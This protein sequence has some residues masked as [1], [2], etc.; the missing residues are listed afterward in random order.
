M[1]LLKV[2]RRGDCYN[3]LKK[4]LYREE[5]WLCRMGY[6]LLMARIVDNKS[7]LK[8]KILRRAELDCS[9]RYCD[10]STLL[11]ATCMAEWFWKKL[12]ASLCIE[13]PLLYVLD[14]IK[15]DFVGLGTQDPKVVV[16]VYNSLAECDIPPQCYPL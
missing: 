5:N 16:M 11:Y 12:D 6:I 4:K 14:R 7:Q 8:A 2:F 3:K 13:L 10:F 9:S 1:R 15:L